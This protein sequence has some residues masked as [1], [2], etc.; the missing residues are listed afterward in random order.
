MA[1]Q[2]MELDSIDSSLK[3]VIDLTGDE[4]EPM[5]KKPRR[6]RT[7]KTEVEQLNS[8][9]IV[10]SV[11]GMFSRREPVEFVLDSGVAAHILD[12]VMPYEED[13]ALRQL[14]AWLCDVVGL[15]DLKET[16]KREQ[17]EAKAE[18]ELFLD[19][20]HHDIYPVSFL[21]F[22]DAIDG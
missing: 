2:F 20:G 3:R 15:D 18:L 19:R 11:A 1:Q 5:P 12:Y 8:S 6:A 9:S 16:R 21:V 4:D 13:D 17:E 7:R 22:A 10:A 14:R